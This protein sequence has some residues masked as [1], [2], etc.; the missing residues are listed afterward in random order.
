MYLLGFCF[1]VC[2]WRFFASRLSNRHPSSAYG[3]AILSRTLSVGQQTPT[4]LDP[5]EAKKKRNSRNQESGIV[6]QKSESGIRNPG[7]PVFGNCK[8][9]KLCFN[10]GPHRPARGQAQIDAVRHKSRGIREKNPFYTKVT[11]HNFV[12]TP[13]ARCL[14][15]RNR[16][17][18]SW[19]TRIGN[20]T[21]AT[22]SY[23]G[24]ER[25]KHLASNEETS[26]VQRTN[27]K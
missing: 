21:D 4:C 14:L 15:P 18:L 7:K 27:Q 20:R 8:K 26:L 19:S 2:I 10:Y 16:G 6:N 13:F 1:A 22:Y 25:E 5:L 9:K 11:T 24:E 12:P 3:A 17:T 23:I